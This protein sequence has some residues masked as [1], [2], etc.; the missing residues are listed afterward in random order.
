MQVLA[1]TYKGKKHFSI[2]LFPNI[3]G[4][5]CEVFYDYQLFSS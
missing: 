5:I 4:N 3:Y 1:H 2:N